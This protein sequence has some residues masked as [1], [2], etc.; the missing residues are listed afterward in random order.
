[1]LVL[2]REIDQEIYIDGGRIKLLVVEVRN[3][4]VRIGIT[5]PKDVL[6]HR[7]EI[8]EKTQEEQNGGES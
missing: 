5:A 2:A 3:G 6:I 7:K 8:W 4:K 1:M